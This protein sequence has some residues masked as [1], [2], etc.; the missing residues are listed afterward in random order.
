MGEKYVILF[1]IG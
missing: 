1:P